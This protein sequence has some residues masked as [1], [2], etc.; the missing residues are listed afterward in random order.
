MNQEPQDYDNSVSDNEQPQ[1]SYFAYGVPMEPNVDDDDNGGDGEI[2]SRMLVRLD[3]PSPAEML[4]AQVQPPPADRH[5]ALVYLKRLAPG[6]QPTMR[7]ALQVSAELLS[8]GRCTWQTMPWHLL[9][10]QHTKALRAELAYRYAPATANKMLAAVRGVLR[11]CWELD[12]MTGEQYQRS[13]AV[14]AVKGDRLMRGRALTPGELRTLFQVCKADKSPAGARDAALIAVLYGSGL[15]R[16]EAVALDIGDYDE[17]EESLTIRAGKGN[18]QRVCYMASGQG[19]LL[20][21][22]LQLRGKLPGPLF[23]AIAKGGNIKSRRISDRAVLYIVMRRAKMAGVNHFSPHDLRR[24]MIGDLLDAGADI[25]TV[26][27]LAGHANVQTTTRYDR[28]GEATR[29][30]AAKLLHIPDLD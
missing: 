30:K 28:R 2:P 12:Q 23:C 4:R 15:R 9:R 13:A 7:N 16:S 18:K 10:A 11:E 6:S 25:S 24:T 20:E 3:S 21:R 22:W 26:Q 8:G 27:K 14:R 29:K 5:P 19:A 1:V 17:E